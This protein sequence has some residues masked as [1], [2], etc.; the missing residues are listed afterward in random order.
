MSLNI[1]F[2]NETLIKSRTAISDSIDGKQIKPTIKLAQDKYIMPALGTGL[3]NR[4][5][6][7]IDDNNL[8]A[9]EKMLLDDYIT[10]TLLWFTI[11]EMVMSTSYQFFSKG[12]LQKSSEESNTPSKGQLELLERKYMSNGEF[13][14]QRL[15]D[16]LREN[17]TMF[18]QYLQYGSGFD[19]IAPQ[20]Q[21]YTSPIFLGKRSTRRRV[22]NLDLPYPYNYEDTQ[23]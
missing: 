17:S 9:N 11:G 16:F 21:A 13:Y 3:Y 5:Q 14:K 4:L 20:V 23:L 10:D 15:I 19:V 22:S 12:V 7:G 6:E 1:L 18:E 2:I 8:S